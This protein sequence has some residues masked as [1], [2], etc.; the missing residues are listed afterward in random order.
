MTSIPPS[1]R[2]DREPG[3]PNPTGQ[4]VEEAQATDG[5]ARE[6]DGQ[7]P[8]L[9]EGDGSETPH[10]ASVAED[11][12]WDAEAL[13]GGRDDPLL[14]SLVT[15]TGLLERPMS[16]GA[17]TAGLPLPDD[18]LT[19]ELFIRAAGR[20]GLTA[21]LVKRR[22][23]QIS[24]LT[25]PCVL[26]LKGRSACVLVDFEKRKTADIIVPE[27]GGDVSRVPVEELAE[28]YIGHALFAQ[29]QHGF[30]GRVEADVQQPK[31]WFWGTLL[32]F[33]PIYGEVVLAAFLINT[34]ALVTP[35][36]IMNVYDRVVPNNAIE[37]LWVLAVGVA[38]VLGFDFVLRILRSHF[39]D[40][41][42]RGADTLIASR[43][44][45]HVMGMRMAA[46][47]QSGG[48]LA[49]HLREFESL[50][51]FFTSATLVTLIDLPFVFLFIAV[52]WYVGGPVAYVPLIA[53]P[54]V[55]GIG[56]LLQIPLT[57]VVRR[58]YSESAQKHG[59]LFE[60]IGG[61]ETVKSMGAEG[62]VQRR[63]E[64][65]V[66]RSA[67]SSAR[68]RGVATLAISFAALSQ[69]LVIVG[70]VV[71]GVYQIAEGE[72]TVGALVAVTI[73]AGRAMAP[74]AQI[75]GLCTR[76]QQSRVALKALDNIMKM[77]IE[78]PEER[79]FLH[80]PSFKGSIEFKNVAF[81]YPGQKTPVLNGLSFRIGAGERVGV[82][83]KIGSG[84]STIERL[85][86]GLFE[87]AS[88]SVLIDGT[89]VRQ[90]DPADLR[91]NIGCVPQEVYLFSG[92]IR[93]NITFSAPDA[94][95]AAVLRAAR[96]AGVEDFVRL[97]PLGF[98]LPVGER[99]DAV[100]G[101]Q[102]QT[103]AIAR[104]LIS[105][106]P[107]LVF[108]EPTSAMDSG[109]ENQ[110]KSRLQEILDDKTL[111]LITHRASLLSLVNRL[112]VIDGGKVVADGPRDI[113]LQRLSSKGIRSVS[114]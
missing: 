75:A 52:I 74:L 31:A 101:G 103:I 102:R 57:L 100:S 1:D 37:T 107:I 83:G 99:G 86:L 66:G 11:A 88:G 8:S 63:W 56:L 46:R 15:L 5:S 13:S 92:S 98:D 96:I 17:L 23:K 76:F 72:M 64:S 111:V 41:A 94:D 33:W 12:D 7:E 27:S 71:Y 87:P 62:R 93:D 10:V 20:A 32:K 25:L 29:P 30:E 35:L 44:F 67:K 3:E 49:S 70:V 104:A 36:F 81:S 77:P 113:V 114:G 50:R 16:A 21:R 85:I 2:R 51:D 61:L 95:D 60:A 48:E 19:P 91:R 55:L 53:V 80:R 45:Q 6:P 26:L 18:G 14:A 40:A 24:R 97:H 84:K 69:S 22:L 28:Q 106:R 112:I 82:I 79:A 42:G 4:D 105:D 38:T 39:A 9:A 34:F 110:F 108:D 43:M 58:S 68:A 73:L 59:L 78:R 89:D 47:P 65:L 90:I 54:I 109:S